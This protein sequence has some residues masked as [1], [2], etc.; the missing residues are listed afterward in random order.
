MLDESKNHLYDLLNEIDPLP[1]LAPKVAAAIRSLY[2]GEPAVFTTWFC[3]SGASEAEMIGVWEQAEG[4]K[5]NGLETLESLIVF[6][7]YAAHVGQLREELVFTKEDAE[8]APEGRDLYRGMIHSTLVTCFSAE[9]GGCKSLLG[10]CVAREMEENGLK[11]VICQADEGIAGLRRD[12]YDSEHH[13]GI[14]YFKASMMSDGPARVW[15]LLSTVEEAAQHGATAEQLRDV[16][17]LPDVWIFDTL[18]KFFDPDDASRKR[19]IEPMQKL[20]RFAGYT[21]SAIVLLHHHNKDGPD[22]QKAKD[23]HGGK[24]NVKNQLD[25]LFYLEH[26]HSE[27]VARVTVIV[28]K[29][30]GTVK[31]GEHLYEF[32]IDLATLD[33]KV[34][35]PVDSA[36]DA[37]IRAQKESDKPTVDAIKH[38]LDIAGYKKTDLL[39]QLT[40]SKAKNPAVYGTNKA[41][42]VLED[43]LYLNQPHH[44]ACTKTGEKNTAYFYAIG[45]NEETPPQ[46][47]Q[48]SKYQ[49]Q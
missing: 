46:I 5:S 13:P 28:Q 27:N 24:R 29:Y 9:S 2:P 21:D 35:V 10:N 31:P 6:Q 30:R 40:V 4:K 36:R 1:N 8:A 43:P 37:R 45:A 7:R 44:W 25:A 22:L 11:V 32:A 34:S 19:I 49:G 42:K 23:K 3:E 15:D 16:F 33:M 20:S 41:R 26:E 38:W 48:I 47:T 17:D 14:S 39:E 12:F 18:D